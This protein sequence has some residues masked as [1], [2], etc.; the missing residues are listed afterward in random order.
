MSC[1]SDNFL[2]VQQEARR[3]PRIKP[4]RFLEVTRLLDERFL[5]GISVV[6]ALETQGLHY[7]LLTHA[8]TTTR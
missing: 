1:Y 7:E 2:G 4:S 3:D 6:Y 8:D 5:Y